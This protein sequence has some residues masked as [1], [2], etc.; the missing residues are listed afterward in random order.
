MSASRRLSRTSYQMSALW[1]TL[2]PRR[3][4]LRSILQAANSR[5]AIAPPIT[6]QTVMRG[7][8]TAQYRNHFRANP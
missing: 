3:L 5:M 1:V 8:Y 7:R 6:A 4:T 2:E